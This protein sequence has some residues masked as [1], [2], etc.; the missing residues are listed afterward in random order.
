MQ[1]VSPEPTP[2]GTATPGSAAPTPGAGG[3][4][5]GPASAPATEAPAAAGANALLTITI[6]QDATADPVQ[7]TLECVDGESGSAT[8]LPDAGNACAALARLGTEFFTARP[9]KDVICTQ[10]YGGP[11]TASITGELDG[12]PVLAAFS[13]TDGCQISRWNSIQDILGAPGA[14]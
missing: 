12:T 10:Q 11:Q 4:P 8:T 1:S 7:Y 3:T 2:S 13:L 6:Q 14:L 5:S 9:D